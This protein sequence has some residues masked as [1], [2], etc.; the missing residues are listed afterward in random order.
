M[1]SLAVS[2]KRSVREPVGKSLIAVCSAIPALRSPLSNMGITPSCF[3][4]R[5]V[6]VPFT[7]RSGGLMIAGGGNV[8]LSFQL[9]WTG[10]DYYEP[11]TRTVIENLAMKSRAFI[12]VGAN[13][14]F[15]T[16]V[17]GAVNPQLRQFAFEPNPKMFALLTEHKRL[18]GLSNLTA[19]QMAVSDSD[20][21]ANLFLNGSDMSA[22]LEPDFQADFNPARGSVS[23][24]TVTLDS[25][26]EQQGITGPLL[27]K[28]DVEGHDKAFLEGG[29][30]TFAGL[31]PDLIIE[32]LSDFD[33]AAIERF[34]RNGYRFYRITD[35]G[36]LESKKVTLTKKGDF[37]F[38]NY[39]FTT[40]SATELDEI[41][42][43]IRERARHI[44][45]YRTSKFADH[46]VNG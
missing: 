23:V 32:V 26:I 3:G 12:D 16:L 13:I 8:H 15:F 9:F 44:N 34:Q 11:F 24:K 40:R 6:R 43:H 42:N 14:G 28:V 38:F 33:P 30:G 35:E 37:V 27:L 2:L 18:N 25:Y 19:E 1:S 10:M 4:N 7:D 21:A 22:S 17:A 5:T 41:S 36:L 31:R 39:L 29:Q 46:P 45:L 20:G